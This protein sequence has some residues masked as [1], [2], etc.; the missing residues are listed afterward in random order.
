VFNQ[1]P[2]R[3]AQATSGGGVT[4]IEFELSRASAWPAWYFLAQD[5]HVSGR[6]QS[7]IR[8]VPLAGTLACADQESANDGKIA[9]VI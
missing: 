7:G 1:W 6:H 8:T 9:L 2:L 4:G 5:L 3:V